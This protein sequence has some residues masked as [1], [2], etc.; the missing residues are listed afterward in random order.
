MILLIEN[1]S[2]HES[3]CQNLSFVSTYKILSKN[4][5]KIIE[6]YVD[7]EKIF[8]KHINEFHNRVFE[9]FKT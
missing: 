8:S 6:F 9:M 1:D 3:I 2:H 5:T 7:F 4:E